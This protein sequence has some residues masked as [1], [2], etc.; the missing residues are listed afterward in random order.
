MKIA[1][2]TGGIQEHY[3]LDGTY[4]LVRQCGFDAVD[5][6]LDHLV[7]YSDICQKRIPKVLTDG[8]VYSIRE[9]SAPWRDG[10]KKYGIENYQAHAPFPCYIWNGNDDGYNDAIL[11]AL[12]N[13]ILAANEIGCRNLVIH[14]FFLPYEHRLSPEDERAL[15]LERYSR[16]I[17]AAKEYGVTICLENMFI[18]RMGKIYAACCSDIGEACGYVDELNRIAGSDTFGFCLDTGHL[19]LCGLDIKDAMDRLGGRIRAFHVHDNNGIDDQHLAPYMGVLDWNRFTQGLRGIEFN[20][21]MSFETFNIWNTVD[22][23]VAPELL[24][25]IAK[26]GRMFA[27]RAGKGE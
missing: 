2:Q 24:R 21:T 22:A 18:R 8:S 14:P 26:C 12:K 9:L 20:E 17:P 1:V 10:A 15:N 16:L 13:S 11:R 6:N 25:F 3:G 19:L 23:E 7:S 27:R 4:R 5:A